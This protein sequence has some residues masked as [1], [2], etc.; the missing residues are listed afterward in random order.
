MDR[1]LTQNFNQMHD[2]FDG[3]QLLCDELRKDLTMQLLLPASK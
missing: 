2:A 3:D 1:W